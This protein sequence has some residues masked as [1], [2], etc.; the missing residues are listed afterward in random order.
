VV[1]SGGVSVGEADFTKQMMAKLGESGVL[2]N[3]HAPGPPDGLRQHP[4]SREIGVSLGLPGNPVAS[5]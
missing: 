1:T 3:R 5:W 4:R 2:E